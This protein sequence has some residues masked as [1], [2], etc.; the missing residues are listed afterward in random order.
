MENR[1]YPMR[2]LLADMQMQ[3][4]EPAAALNEYEASMKDAPERLR[5][6]YGAA[7]AAAASGNRGKVGSLFQHI[8]W[9]G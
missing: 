6:F 3:Q 4:G 8:A 5:G 7:K 2:E 1:L 9:R